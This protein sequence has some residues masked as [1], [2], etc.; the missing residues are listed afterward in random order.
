MK[1][2]NNRIFEK[3]IKI[4]LVL[5]F[6]IIALLCVGFS[7][8]TRSLFADYK[9]N[10]EQYRYS[11]QIL[12]E[13]NNLV[14]QFYNLQEYEK[15]FLM[16]KEERYLNLYQTEIDTFQQKFERIMRF[17]QYED[18]KYF[19]DITD[20]LKQKKTML[21]ELRQW[22]ENKKDVDSLY[23]KTTDRIDKKIEQG[24]P[25]ITKSIALDT[26]TQ[27]SLEIILGLDSLYKFTRQYQFQ[28]K[29]QI[30]RIENECYA[31]LTTDH[32]NTQIITTQLTQ[33]QGELLRNVIS[34]GETHEVQAHRALISSVVA[35]SIALL[36][37]ALFFTF[38]FKKIKTMRTL[39]EVLVSDKQKIED[40]MEARR[41]LMMTISHDI[42]TPLHAL[43]GYL[44]LWKG[45][46]LSSKKHKE[47]NTMQYAGK[48]IL[49]LL[50]NLL[51]FTRLEQQKSQITKEVIDVVP[52]FMEMIEMF[53]PLCDKKNKLTYNIN[54][55]DNPQILI[56]SLKLKQIVI[57]LVSNAIKYT[58][59]GVIHL[60]VEEM[61]NHNLQLKVTVAD[62]GKG[63]P[64]EQ[65]ASLCE[66]FTRVEKN[67]VGVE[68]NG[69]GL[70]VVKGL[71]DLMEGKI[72]IQTEENAGTTVTV[73]I[74]CEPVIV[75]TQSVT[76]AR[77]SLKIW[78]IED[79]ATQLQVVVSMLRKMGH[80]AT[81][82]DTKN[83]FET[84][85][86]T[87]LP[88]D[89]V[90]TDLEM[91]DLKGS[92]VV[93]KIKSIANIPVVC[94][95]GNNTT[96]LIELREIGFDDFLA[97]PFTFQELEKVLTSIQKQQANDAT[98][99]YSLDTLYELFG[100]DTETIN[101]LLNTF[102]HAL[103]ND[104]QEFEFALEFENLSLAQQ[105]A[106]RL[107]PF[108]KQIKANDVIPLLEKIEHS[109]KQND[110]IF[111]DIKVEVELLVSNLKKLLSVLN[112]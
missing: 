96:S 89:V 74:P 38:L 108:C 112:C 4:Q 29:T 59:H 94:L 77:K 33:L 98:S 21:K 36:L 91:G 7:V 63:I 46:A 67:S 79:D 106:H 27:K 6:T 15:L 109:K 95:S 60:L 93:Q 9:K 103:P 73:F 40:L 71:V 81:T 55:N 99:L 14:S 83:G 37:I 80:K 24:I 84:Y 69:L 57:N 11:K 76:I 53:R 25:Q 13:T 61:S 42:K 51:E 17:M 111:K 65:I 34:L 87:P 82:T 88:F 75:D 48:Y 10:Q 104:I 90:F 50:N 54:V 22:Y 31:L 86:K 30:E 45:D 68:G 78:V 43:L 18:N 92:D 66:P 5:V 100:N 85:M 3:N 8:L 2:K 49:S 26:T 32:N 101:S 12:L 39:H 1:T 58:N 72:E 41:Q 62:N 105:T 97:K 44:E 107:L 47:L 28:Y 16:Q 52:F 19:T 20:L 64:K 102:A 70:F 23:K 110:V 56:D 35:G